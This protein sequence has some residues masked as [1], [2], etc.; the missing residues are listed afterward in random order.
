MHR[1]RKNDHVMFTCEI[2]IT[3]SKIVKN[4]IVLVLINIIKLI[5]IS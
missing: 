1:K 3:E 2:I 4:G 5:I